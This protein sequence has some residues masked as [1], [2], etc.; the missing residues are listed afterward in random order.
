MGDTKRI[1]FLLLVLCL[2]LCLAGCT[3]SKGKDSG[4]DTTGKNSDTAV[5]TSDS[6]TKKNTALSA[7][8]SD[9]KYGFQLEMPEVGE[10][11]AVLKTNMG[12]IYLRLFP[13]A[14]PKAVENFKTHIKNGY[15][16]GHIFHRVIKDFMIQG[17][18]PTATGSG[19]ESIWG[20]DFEDEFSDKLLNITGALSMANSGE[21][22]NGS[23]F[24]I[25]Q[26][27]SEYANGSEIKQY[28]SEVYDYVKNQ[29]KSSYG[30]L[31]GWEQYAS[32]NGIVNSNKVPSAVW[33]LYAKNGGN[34]NL[35]GAWRKTGGHTVFGQV[36][37][38]MDVVKAI[39]SVSTDSN[40][41][42]HKDVVIN[43]AEIVI[44]NQDDFQ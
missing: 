34:I 24:F 40:D 5:D 27:V 22:T 4:N 15:Y 9:K 39:A 38:G 1:R 3:G 26:C 42:P 25:N 11:I 30:N 13:E 10:E 28:Y 31:N 37:K 7:A 35:D 18:D 19:G 21:D 29:Y 36:I 32:Q 41:K 8:Y 23:Q 16:N 33:D 2:V 17:G 20:S 12:D 6:S 43:S 14:A 44:F